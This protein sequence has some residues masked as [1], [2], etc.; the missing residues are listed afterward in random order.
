[1]TPRIFMLIAMSSAACIALPA[2]AQTDSG[3][4][5]QDAQEQPVTQTLNRD[6]A[7]EAATAGAANE[8]NQAQYDLDRAA[9][10]AEVVSRREKIMFDEATYAR[11]QAAYADAMAA[12]R[13]QTDECKRGI[14]KACKQPTPVPADFF[15]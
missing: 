3:R 11:Q 1:M 10:R 4:P 2:S 9:Y 8:A 7:A 12:W 15:R 13:L 6:G 5:A 14:L